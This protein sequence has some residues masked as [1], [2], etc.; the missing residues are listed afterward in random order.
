MR[1]SRFTVEQMIQ[2][3]RAGPLPSPSPSPAAPQGH[4]HPPS[5]GA[6]F[7]SPVRLATARPGGS[8]V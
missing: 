6:K 1:R 3:L 7:D 8:R 4:C 2:I 5:A